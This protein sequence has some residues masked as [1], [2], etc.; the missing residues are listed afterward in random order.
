MRR[1]AAS[2]S[3]TIFLVLALAW[4]VP[5]GHVRASETINGISRRAAGATVGTPVFCVWRH[6]PRESHVFATL[7]YVTPDIP[8]YDHSP[9]RLAEALA[10]TCC[11]V[12]P[13][14]T[15]TLVRDGQ[16]VAKGRI[17]ALYAAMVP[18]G[19]ESYRAYFDAEGFADSVVDGKALP[20][21]AP[22]RDPGGA[23]DLY[24]VGDGV[25]T[26]LTPAVKNGDAGREHLAAVAAEAIDL[27]ALSLRTLPD[28][29]RDPQNR[30]AWPTP[31]RLAEFWRHDAVLTD[32]QLP[33][34]D[35]A[36]ALVQVL[37]WWPQREPTHGIVRVSSPGMPKAAFMGGH[38]EYFLRVDDVTYIVMTD[39]EPETGMWGYSVY[40]LRPG[41]A[42][43]RVLSDGSW[44][45]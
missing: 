22:D 2:A 35:G 13:G 12:R 8:D 39:R 45:T 43:E 11:A 36:T 18:A 30:A 6:L 14:Q 26:P 5:E 9:P 31:A 24:V 40:R 33:V 7:E 41:R 42:P 25:V 44:S 15:L 32:F 3:G 16:V 17:G 37:N 19:G 34:G 4:L 10:D 20:Y 1:P 21:N 28:S 38:L 29:L 27:R 23:F